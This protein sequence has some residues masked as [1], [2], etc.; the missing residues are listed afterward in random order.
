MFLESLQH[1][2]KTLGLHLVV[3][4]FGFIYLVDCG[5]QHSSLGLEY[6][7]GF[8]LWFQHFLSIFSLWTAALQC[9]LPVHL[10]TSQSYRDELLSV[11]EN[12]TQFACDSSFHLCILWEKISSAPE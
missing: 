12:I 5:R 4:L 10:L 6:N 8:L 1:S 2:L 3:S 11:A 9:L 7:C